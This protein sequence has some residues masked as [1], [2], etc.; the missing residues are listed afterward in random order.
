[1]EQKTAFFNLVSN[2][3]QLLPA[4][5]PGKNVLVAQIYQEMKQQQIHKQ[6]WE[7]WIKQRLNRG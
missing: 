6:Q 3:K 7:G 4:N 5:H 1:M 2:L